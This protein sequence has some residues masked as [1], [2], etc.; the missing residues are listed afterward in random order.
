M[1]LLACDL[2]GTKVLIGI[3]QQIK[4]GP[5]KLLSKQ[6][7]KS[8]NWNSFDEILDDFIRSQDLDSSLLVACF[9]IAGAIKGNAGQITN[10]SW[11]ISCSHLKNKYNFLDLEIINDFAVQIYGIP[12]KIKKEIL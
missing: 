4:N 12:F 6:K 9:A 8:S 5:P 3:F 10:L 11:K 1:K 2:G 7:Y